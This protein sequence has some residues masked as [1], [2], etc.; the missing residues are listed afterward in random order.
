[1]P[2]HLLREAR[3]MT[4][5]QLAKL[6][7]VNQGAVSKL[8]P[9]ADRCVN[10]P[11]RFVKAGGGELKITARFPAGTVEIS[12]FDLTPGPRRLGL[13][14]CGVLWVRA[15]RTELVRTS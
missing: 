14:L 12:Q 2:V 1:M 11:Q 9:R 8:E 4:P 10:T 15:G 6:W 3:E 7:G 5:V 13:R